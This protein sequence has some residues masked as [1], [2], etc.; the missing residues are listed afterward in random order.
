MAL[1]A[2]VN[3]R[4]SILR[5]LAENHNQYLAG[6]RAFAREIALKKGE[7]TVD[8]VREAIERERYPMPGEIGC[9]ERVLGALFKTRDFRAVGHRQTS[10]VEWAARVGAARS[11][12]TVY[13]LRQVTAA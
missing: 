12:V 8:D 1:L 3:E 4:D 10:R 11:L 7:V 2:A 13:E 9:D 5:T 6:L